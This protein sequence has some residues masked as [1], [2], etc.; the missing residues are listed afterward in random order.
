MLIRLELVN[1]N[2]DKEVFVDLNEYEQTGRILYKEFCKLVRKLLNPEIDQTEYNLHTIQARAKDADSLK[3]KLIKANLLSSNTIENEIKDLAGCR[4]IFYLNS[5]VQ[6]F[7]SSGIV[8]DVFKVIRETYKVHHPKDEIQSSNDFYMADHFVVEL[9]DELLSKPD[10][11]KFQGLRCEIQ[12]CTILNHAYAA[13][14][15]KIYKKPEVAGFASEGFKNIE[16]R[17]ISLAENHIVQAGYEFQKIYD[18]LQD[19]SVGKAIYERRILK[20]V[21]S[22]I[23]N[24]ER[25]NLLHQFLKYTLPHFDDINKEFPEIIDIV[26]SSLQAAKISENISINTSFGSFPGKSN[27]D[28]FVE[29]LQILDYVRYVDPEKIFAEYLELYDDPECLDKK[30]ILSKIENLAD[31]NY[32]ILGKAGYFVQECL[33]LHISRLDSSAMLKFKPV[34]LKICESIFETKFERTIFEYNSVTFADGNLP[35]SLKLLDIREKAIGFLKELLKISTT[36]VEKY[37]IFKALKSSMRTPSMRDYDDELLLIILKNSSEIVRHYTEMVSSLSYELSSLVEASFFST[38]KVAKSIVKRK[39][40]SSDVLS[41]AK[42]FKDELK[43]FGKCINQDAHYIVYKTLI[44]GRTVFK[45]EWAKKSFSYEQ[46]K[47]HRSGQVD[48]FIASIKTKNEEYWADIIVRCSKTQTDDKSVLAYYVQFLELIGKNKPSFAY[49]LISDR[50][51]K[52]SNDLCYLMVGLVE[53]SLKDDTFELSR[54]WISEGKYLSQLVWVYRRTNYLDNEILVKFANK[55]IEFKDTFTLKYLISAVIQNFDTENKVLIK[56]VVIPA[57]AHLTVNKNATWVAVGLINPNKADV[58]FDAMDDLDI[59]VVL[60]NLVYLRSIDY[61]SE[62]ALLPIAN[63]YPQKMIAFFGRRLTIKPIDRSRYDRLPYSFDRLREPLAG[64][65]DLLLD[66]AIK[67]YQD[68]A[69]NFKHKGARFI[70]L[71]FPNFNKSLEQSLQALLHKNFELYLPMVL[72]VLGNYSGEL[73]LYDT[74]KIIVALLPDDS[75]FLVEIGSIMLGQ[76][77]IISTSGEFGMAEFYKDK[78][79][80]IQAWEDEGDPKIKQFAKKLLQRVDNNI[81]FE[82]RRAEQ[83]I[84]RRKRG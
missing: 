2:Y 37:E 70:K 11:L 29:C 6:R 27:S 9:S 64:H 21:S 58:F 83:D 53:S 15:H 19:L 57:V 66:A 65:A 28:V 39:D 43:E 72:S 63:R 44:A 23:S 32:K 79:T 47:L 4:I 46:Q 51:E 24:H 10:Y 74:C 52:L 62:L 84:A 49:K 33:C 48:K 5:D 78:K 7:M 25:Y 55:V 82:K 17:L 14:N 26:R 20:E 71:M 59:D 67:W 61:A 56:N 42:K 3:E 40:L 35:G 81:G 54:K 31:F 80:Q 50:N 41:Q 75:K 34:I 76:S 12:V 13:M 73:F 8:D 36:D 22:S 18:D 1:R 30:L 60:E 45:Q 38:Y 68:N 69:D 16:D 77:N